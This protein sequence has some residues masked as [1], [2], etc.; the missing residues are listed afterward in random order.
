M[1]EAVRA[2]L[3]YAFAELRLQ[4]VTVTTLLTMSAAAG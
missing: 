3:R 2:A 1:T 4:L